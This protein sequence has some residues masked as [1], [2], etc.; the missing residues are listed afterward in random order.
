M[1]EYLDKT[2]HAVAPDARLLRIYW[3]DGLLKTMRPSLAQNLIGQSC[4]TKLR[5][6][7]VNS[8]MGQFY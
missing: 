6:G 3:Y 2:A 1:I 7:L 5:L 4:N 8:R